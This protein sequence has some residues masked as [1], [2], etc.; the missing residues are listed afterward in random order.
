MRFVVVAV[1]L[2]ATSPTTAWIYWIAPDNYRPDDRVQMQKAN[3]KD[4]WWPFSSRSVSDL[5]FGRG[6]EEDDV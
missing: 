2:W 1:V 6:V 3:M 5:V 4:N